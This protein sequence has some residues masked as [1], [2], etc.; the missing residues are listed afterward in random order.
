MV[1]DS[2][3]WAEGSAVLWLC[4]VAT[5]ASTST[6][7][8]ARIGIFFMCLFLSNVRRTATRYGQRTSNAGIHFPV[9]IQLSISEQSRVVQL[10][11]FR[12]G[13]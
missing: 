13:G 12:L 1:K 3:V 7:A 10:R 6:A 9:F 11:L 4:N 5:P 8:V 2:V